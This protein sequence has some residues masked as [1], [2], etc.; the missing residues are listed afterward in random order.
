MRRRGSCQDNSLLLFCLMGVGTFLI[1]RRGEVVPPDGLDFQVGRATY[2]LLTDHSVSDFF[3]FCSEM[4]CVADVRGY[5][6]RL[7]PAWTKTLGWSIEELSSRPYIEFVHP[8]D[9]AATLHEASLLQSD[10]YETVKLPN[11]Y[12]C[13]GGSYKWLSWRAKTNSGSGDLLVTTPARGSSF[14]VRFVQRRRILRFHNVRP[15]PCDAGPIADHG[16]ASFP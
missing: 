1:E 10:Q 8:D 16:T 13:K 15:G 6:V 12:R 5:F 9:L 2:F 7:N 3:D 14:S 4:V 11:R